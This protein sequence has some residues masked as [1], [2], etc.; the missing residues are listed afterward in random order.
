MAWLTDL[1]KEPG[2]DKSYNPLN[3]SNFLINGAKY[4][5]TANIPIK[6]IRLPINLSVI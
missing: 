4:K 5:L 1:G 2:V 3:P 6:N